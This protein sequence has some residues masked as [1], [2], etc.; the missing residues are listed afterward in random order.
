MSP[1][2]RIVLKTVKECIG[3]QKHLNNRM[4]RKKSKELTSGSE[5]L[6]RMFTF[7]E[8]SYRDGCWSMEREVDVNAIA[9]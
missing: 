5:E 3:F 1:F 2:L 7:E 6:S 4:I 9:V 8:W